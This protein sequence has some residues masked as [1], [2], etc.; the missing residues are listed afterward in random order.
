LRK[1]DLLPMQAFPINQPDATPNRNAV[2]CRW[3]SAA[4][5]ANR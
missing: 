1:S 4:Q 5:Y 2:L 3:C